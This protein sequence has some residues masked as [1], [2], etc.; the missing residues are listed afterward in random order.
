MP[1]EAATLR[2]WI[3]AWYLAALLVALKSSCRIYFSCSPLGEMKMMPA[4]ALSRL[5]APSKYMIQCSGCS[6]GGGSW[7]SVH[8]AMKSARVVT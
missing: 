4:P 1:R 2:P 3:R 7:I 5:R 6:S 8:S